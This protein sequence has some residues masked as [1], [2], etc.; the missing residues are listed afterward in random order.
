MV[1][2]YLISVLPVLLSLHLSGDSVFLIPRV[3]SVPGSPAY[4]SCIDI[5]HSAFYSINQNSVQIPTS[6]VDSEGKVSREEL[7]GPEEEETVIKTYY[8][9]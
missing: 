4:Y 8:I 5:G 3:L 9:K 7:V 1:A 2:H 6:W